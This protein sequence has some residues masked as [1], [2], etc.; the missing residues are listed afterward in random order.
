MVVLYNSP[1]GNINDVMRGR[2]DRI[3]GFIV[4]HQGRSQFTEDE[5]NLLE[6]EYALKSDRILPWLA[7]EWNCILDLDGARTLDTV[8][9]RGDP[10]IPGSYVGSTLWDATKTPSPVSARATVHR[11]GSI[12]IYSRSEFP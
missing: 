3:A 7:N 1:P 8:T 12:A 5:F 4:A 9:L 6:E 11:N 10:S 2:P